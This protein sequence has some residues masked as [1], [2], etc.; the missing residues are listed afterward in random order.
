MVLKKTMKP[1]K[2][3]GTT[4][5]HKKIKKPENIL[6]LLESG[7]EI[8]DYIAT[9][10]YF[11]ASYLDIIYGGDHSYTSLKDKYIKVKN[12]LKIT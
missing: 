10:K 2:N 5:N 3:T 11:A 1:E 4:Q 6:I 12:F 9:T 7:D 8:L